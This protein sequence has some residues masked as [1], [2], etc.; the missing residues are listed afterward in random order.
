MISHEYKCIFVH[1]PRTAGTNIERA[2]CGKNWWEID[3]PTKH[4]FASTAKELYKEYWD[5]Y[6]KFSFVRDPWDRMIS[7]TTF[8]K[9]YGC[10]IVNGKLNIDEYI[11]KYNR[12]EI[13]SRSKSISDNIV[14]KYDSIYS[15]ILN[16]ELDFIGRF[17]N[18]EEDFE[19]VKSMI[20]LTKPLPHGRKKSAKRKK[21]MGYYTEEVYNKVYELYEKDII[22]YNYSNFPYDR[23]GNIDNVV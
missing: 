19:Y 1:I 13:D 9:F 11:R 8:E 2:I 3:K 17:E 14:N 16:E 22:K 12:L 5:D 4:I 10:K 21:Y 6:F 20:G 15:N 18:I 23:L 7:M